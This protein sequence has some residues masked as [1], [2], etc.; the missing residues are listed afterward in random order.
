VSTYVFIERNLY[1]VAAAIHRKKVNKGVEDS[2]F[3]F[4]LHKKNKGGCAP[5]GGCWDEQKKKKLSFLFFWRVVLLLLLVGEAI[6]TI[7]FRK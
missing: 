2:I 7:F 4:F 5:G 3:S 1:K 6:I